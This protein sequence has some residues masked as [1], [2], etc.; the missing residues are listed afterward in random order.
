MVEAGREVFVISNDVVPG[1]GMPVAA[2][3]L[4]AF[5][6]A[7]G[8]RANGVGMKTLVTR[9]FVER[10]WMR[11]GRSVPHPTA[12]DTEI[13]GA[14]S[15]ARYLKAH[16]P[17]VAI[18]INS[19]QVD[20]LRPMEGVRYVLD[21]FAPKML[22]ELYHHGEGYPGEDLKR[23]RERKLKA[24]RLAD[25]FI[26]NGRKKVPYFLAW[27][28]QADRDV[29][30]LPLDVVSMCVPLS[31]SGEPGRA[32]GVRLA[33]AGYLQS[34]STLGNWVEVLERRL[35]RPGV[36]L[37]LLVPWHWG[38]VAK[39]SHASRDDLDR[40]SRHPSVTTHGTMSFSGFQR[41]LSTVD[42][43]ID[44]FQHNLEREYAMVTRSVVSLACGVPVIHP[45]FTE[46]SPMIAEY[47]AGW[48]VDPLDSR[49]LGVVLDDI[50][51]DPGAVR[52]KT[53]NAR[54][55]ATAILDP[56]EA[57]K[58]LVKILETL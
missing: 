57:V 20:H 16:A 8:L 24:I 44:L 38:G 56:A 30:S 1:F 25:A 3:G 22:E 26:C 10:Q 36:R 53:K 2:P 12:P 49:T 13:V 37:D 15:L 17:A 11:F 58:P 45:P 4:R 46:V 6:L 28:L 48:L 34:W 18:L 35:D 39:R 52:R 29:R 23:L 31:W 47:D 33:V 50:I 55:L 27:M 32:E 19:N 5:G 41:F 40:I 7:E 54:T 51:E 14:S 43:T 42:V 9:G 21:F